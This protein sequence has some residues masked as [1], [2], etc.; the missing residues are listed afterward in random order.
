MQYA[1]I[2]N[3]LL[4]NRCYISKIYSIYLMRCTLTFIAIYEYRRNFLHA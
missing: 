3:E 4:C 1:S 2:R